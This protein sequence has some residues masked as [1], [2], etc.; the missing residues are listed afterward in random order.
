ME[1]QGKRK[2]GG[3]AG[4]V[5]IVVIIIVAVLF[6]YR[7]SRVLRRETFAGIRAVQETEGKPVEVVTAAAGDIEIWTTLAGTVEGSVQYDIVSTNA[8]RVLEVVRKEGERVEA[9]DVVI[10]LEK[11]APNP[12][13]HSYSRSK[14]VYEDAL[15]DARRMRNLYRE[16]AVSKQMLDKAEMALKIAKSD[17]VNATESSEL[18]ASHAGIVMSV[19]VEE[20]DMAEAHTPLAWIARTDSVRIVFEAGSRQAMAL[21]VGQ[22]AIWHSRLTGESGEGFV[23]RLDLAADP[24]SHLLGGEAFFA[25][26]D[27]DLVPGIL[28]SFRVL[29]GQ[30]LGIIKIPVNCL[31]ESDGGF[32]VYVVEPGDGSGHRARLQAVGTGLR[33]SDEVEIVTGLTPGDM[34]VEFGQ[35][36][37]GDGDLVKIIGGGEGK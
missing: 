17:L 29:T 24:E 28:V 27:G 6:A 11:T 21:E 30:R 1:S 26:P 25:N 2:R 15:A 23:G 33:S 8:I 5:G 37:I 12:M 19:N 18:V 20:G 14:A 3:R 36:R 34:V 10:R 13:L 16:G 9:G 35:T 32:T 22:G 4:T 31:M 7:F